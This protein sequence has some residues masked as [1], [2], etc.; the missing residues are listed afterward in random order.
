MLAGSTWSDAA[1]CDPPA[2]AATNILNIHGTSDLTV[3][4]GGKAPPQWYQT[5]VVLGDLTKLSDC[6][7]F[8]AILL[9]KPETK[10]CYWDI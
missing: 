5:D 10:L 4:I 2:G 9:T 1:R 3:P 6:A 8:W 7:I